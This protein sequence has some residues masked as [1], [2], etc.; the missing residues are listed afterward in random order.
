MIRTTLHLVIF[1]NITAFHRATNV[2]LRYAR[3]KKILS[4]LIFYSKDFMA[5]FLGSC[6]AT[7]SQFFT[8][9]LGWCII[10]SVELRFLFYVRMAACLWVLNVCAPP[11]LPYLQMNLTRYLCGAG[12]KCAHGSLLSSPCS[13]RCVCLIKKC[14]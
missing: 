3:Y 4:L 2:Q 12:V 11:F 13:Q 7:H 8:Q 14:A 1:L 10:Y 5:I 6:R 9:G